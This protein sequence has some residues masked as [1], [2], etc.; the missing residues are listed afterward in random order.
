MD[1]VVFSKIMAAL[2]GGYV[3]TTVFSLLVFFL[4]AD[5]QL[6]DPQTQQLSPEALQ[7]LLASSQWSELLSF[8][9]YTA[10]ALWVFHTKSAKHA[11]AGMLLPSVIGIGLV[12]LLLPPTLIPSIKEVLA[13]L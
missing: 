7:S 5:F 4:I 11:W 1:K 12:Y 3:F 8:A 13:A 6:I 9:V 10:V 2:L